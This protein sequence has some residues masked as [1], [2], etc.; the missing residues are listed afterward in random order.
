[1]GMHVECFDS[2]N[3]PDPNKLEI[4]KQVAVK[5]KIDSDEMPRQKVSF[6]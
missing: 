1:M 3:L 5:N 4:N 6:Q 2:S